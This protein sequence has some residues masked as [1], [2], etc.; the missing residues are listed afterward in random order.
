MMSRMI[1]YY[2][3]VSVISLDF[4]IGCHS[5]GKL[6]RLKRFTGVNAIPPSSVIKAI[7]TPSV[8][9]VCPLSSDQSY[10]FICETDTGG[11]L[12]IENAKF[13]TYDISSTVGQNMTVGNFTTRLD[14][15]EGNNYTST[16]T[17][18][19]LSLSLP[20]NNV[21][22]ILTIR[23]DDTGDAKGG[24]NSTLTINGMGYFT[25]KF[26][27]YYQ[28]SRQAVFDDIHTHTV[29]LQA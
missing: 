18:D 21:N 29:F 1:T 11:M 2:S 19:L 26:F 3:V 25:H 23:C 9:R 6:S 7:L 13:V 4:F 10:S 22:T 24:K 12:W 5:T 20:S 16:A 17:V 15:V 14:S 8:V 27:T 28:S